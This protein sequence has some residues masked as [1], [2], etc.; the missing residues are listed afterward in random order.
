[1]ERIFPEMIAAGWIGREATIAGR[2]KIRVR[3]FSVTLNE[4]RRSLIN[5]TC[6]VRGLCS[7]LF[8][9]LVIFEGGTYWQRMFGQHMS[10]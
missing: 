3:S 9:R 2:I 6:F 1:M 8:A 10:M 4:L 7:G 5:W